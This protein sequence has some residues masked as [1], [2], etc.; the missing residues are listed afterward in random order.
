MLQTF[1]PAQ[2]VF[3]TGIG[4]GSM[5]TKINGGAHP[6]QM[7][8]K[9]KLVKGAEMMKALREATH[10][11]LERNRVAVAQQQAAAKQQGGDVAADSEEHAEGSEDDEDEDANAQPDPADYEHFFHVK[12]G[13]DTIY[14]DPKTGNF[15]KADEK[16][17]AKK[18]ET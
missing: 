12:V 16:D 11:S 9:N 5:G 2:T 13:D 7:S 6:Q 18:A 17:K 3:E 14:I 10:A 4:T 1:R 8:L 15:L